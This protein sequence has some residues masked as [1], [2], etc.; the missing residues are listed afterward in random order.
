MNNM[1]RDCQPAAG[2]ARTAW[3]TSASPT[4]RARA[5]ATALRTFE[6]DGDVAAFAALF[7]DD[8]VTQRF[9]ARGERRGEVAQFWR[10][11]RAQFGSVST[12]FT[13]VGAGGDRFALEWTSDGTLTDG[14]PLQYRG[15][16]VVD[17]YGDVITQLRTYYDSAQFAA[18]AAT[19]S[20]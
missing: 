16:T 1:W 11:Y 17:L 4:N 5:F 7:A 10:E 6:K 13:D 9:D 3:P 18:A 20:D 14:R 19:T 15:M 2:V 8:A 12:T